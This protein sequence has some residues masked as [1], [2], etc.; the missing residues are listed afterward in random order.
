M[1]VV[2]HLFLQRHRYAN[3]SLVTLLYVQVGGDLP[4]N[5]STRPALLALLRQGNEHRPIHYERSSNTAYRDPETRIPSANRAKI[6]YRCS[7]T[8]PA[9]KN[10][11][12]TCSPLNGTEIASILA[13]YLSIAA[14]TRLASPSLNQ[15]LVRK[16]LRD[17]S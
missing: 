5:R 4:S 15:P 2:F 12:I 8:T 14:S 7:K 13:A 1:V 16:G 17:D 9:R 6:R 10:L 11:T 3:P